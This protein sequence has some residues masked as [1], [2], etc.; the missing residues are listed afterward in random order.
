MLSRMNTYIAHELAAAAQLQVKAATLVS[1]YA[2]P[3]DASAA[4]LA[5]L[6]AAVE[7]EALDQG[8]YK[9]TKLVRRFRKFIEQ[10]KEQE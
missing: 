1:T 10:Q 6:M 3:R 4:R 5:L 9:F 8:D 2:E 7:M